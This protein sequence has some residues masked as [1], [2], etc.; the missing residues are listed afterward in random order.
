MNRPIPAVPNVT[1]AIT[2]RGEEL[3]KLVAY[4][5]KHIENRNFRIGEDTIVAIAVG[6]KA[7]E[8][9]EVDALHAILKTYDSPA[10]LYPL[11][12]PT[13]RGHIIGICKV[14]H[15]LTHRECR[16][17][18]WADERW[19][20]CNIITE[21][22]LLPTPVPA[23]GNLG[24]WLMDE[25]VQLAITRQLQDIKLIPTGAAEIYP[26][27]KY[28]IQSTLPYNTLIS[29]TLTQQGTHTHTHRD[30]RHRSRTSA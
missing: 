10:D 7:A 14:S 30:S 20:Y 9:K 26:C 15:T 2:F 28:G 25:D 23:K 19:K 13:M 27:M 3:A 21:A 16:K 18:E 1:H 6:K 11:T 29:Q 12:D 24:K 17:S 22:V 5:I 4:G 8:I